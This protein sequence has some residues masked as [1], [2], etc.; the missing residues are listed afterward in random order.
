MSFEINRR[1]AAPRPALP[2][3]AEIDSVT[4]DIIRGAFETICSGG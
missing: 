4:A 2:T 3:D 1:L